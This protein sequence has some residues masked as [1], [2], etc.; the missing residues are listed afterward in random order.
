MDLFFF[1]L[2]TFETSFKSSK[3]NIDDELYHMQQAKKGL[4]YG[5]YSYR[6][7]CQ[8][9]GTTSRPLGD[10]N[11]KLPLSGATFGPYD[12]VALE[13]EVE[14]LFYSYVIREEEKFQ[15]ILKSFSYVVND[16]WD[17]NCEYRRRMGFKP[18]RSWKLMKQALR[19]KYGVEN[20]EGRGQNQ[21]K[22]KELP[23]AIIESKEVVET[24]VEKE[25]F[26]E[27]SCD[28]MSEKNI[29]VKEIE[30]MEEKERFLERFYIFDSNFI[31][32]KQTEHLECS[33]DRESELVKSERNFE[34]SSKD[35]RGKLAYKIDEYHFNIANYASCVLGVED[36]E[37]SKEKEL[38]SPLSKHFEN[39]KGKYFQMFEGFEQV[40]KMLLLRIFITIYL[41]RTGF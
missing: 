3:L 31:F 40:F 27:D 2:G 21:A 34:D 7:S 24:H 19:N 39:Q 36:K 26:N 37:T 20:H 29:E 32:L 9:L 38:E 28:D 15:F 14:S 4:N 35:E 22:V 41:S 1:E 6:R 11:L 18:I 10:N 23:H 30:R 17:C 16:G 5:G 12:Y 33:K 13:R 25:T 8:T